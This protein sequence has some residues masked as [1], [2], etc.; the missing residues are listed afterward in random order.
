MKIVI[1]I[2]PLS[3]NAAFQGRRFK[4]KLYKDFEDDFDNRIKCAIIT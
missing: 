2:K 4:T 3:I 1:P